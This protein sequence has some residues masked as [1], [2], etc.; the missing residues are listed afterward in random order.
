MLS[1]SKSCDLF[2]SHFYDKKLGPESVHEACL[3]AVATLNRARHPTEELF[4]LIALN[5]FV[6][7]PESR[8]LYWESEVI[9]ASLMAYYLL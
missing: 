7:M 2:T 3:H 1:Q 4:R 6:G 5:S 9:W 8:L